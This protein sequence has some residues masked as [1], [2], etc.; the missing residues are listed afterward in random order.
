MGVAVGSGVGELKA[1][2]DGPAVGIRR[3]GLA[4]RHASLPV[5]IDDDDGRVVAASP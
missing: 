2:V 4:S 5:L 3:P 1:V